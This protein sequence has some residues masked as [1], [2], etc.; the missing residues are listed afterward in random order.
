M[1]WASCPARTTTQNGRSGGKRQNPDAVGR[2][3]C[4][5]R[6]IVAEEGHDHGLV[7][8]LR[9]VAKALLAKRLIRCDAVCDRLDRVRQERVPRVHRVRRDDHP[10]DAHRRTRHRGAGRKTAEA[11]P[12]G[13]DQGDLRGLE[14]PRV[15]HA[16]ARFATMGDQRRARA[17]RA[18]GAEE[19]QRDRAERA[20][21]EAESHAEERPYAERDEEALLAVVDGDRAAAVATGSRR[22]G[23]GRRVGRRRLRGRLRLRSRLRGRVHLRLGSRLRG[24]VRLRLRV[25]LRFRSRLCLC[26]RLGSRRGRRPRLHRTEVDLI[27]GLLHRA[28]VDF[29]RRLGLLV[30]VGIGVELHE[31]AGQRVEGVE[32][33][34]GRAAPDRLRPGIVHVLRRHR[35]VADLGHDARGHSH[36]NADVRDGHAATTKPLRIGRP[37]V[38]C[39]KV[40]P[41]A[42]A[43]DRA[44]VSLFDEMVA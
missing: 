1:R 37:P 10:R 33:L 15:H 29:G 24:R 39:W 8:E 4:V 23:R 25:R 16:S 3:R 34:G 44:F 21:E 40:L 35:V 18:G 30:R 26:L 31:H 38:H 41:G 19:D 42:D 13:R 22:V 5:R 32:L 36:V 14:P 11:P 17:G 2:A 9:V 6:V 12:C 43:R 28:E 20:E 27:R 7:H